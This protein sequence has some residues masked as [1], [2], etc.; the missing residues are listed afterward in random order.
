LTVC[1]NVLIYFDRTTAG[2]TLSGLEGAL[3]PHGMLVIGA[4]D[5]LAGPKPSSTPRRASN[6]ATA[7]PSL[8]RVRAGV[9]RAPTAPAPRSQA[10]RHPGGQRAPVSPGVRPN[11]PEWLRDALRAVHEWN[12]DETVARIGIVLES[13]PLNVDAYFVRGVAQ[14][15]SGDPAGAI[16]SLRRALYLDPGFGLAAFKLARAYE[17]LHDTEGARRA[18]RRALQ[19]LRPDDARD[20]ALLERLDVGNV[21]SACRARL[22]QL[23]GRD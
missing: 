17:D 21:A 13:D 14:L 11:R 19:S 18:Y 8:P 3:H 15:A 22:R 9:Q 4:A 20:A 7:S 5:R 16:A 1:R 10:K 6:A 12:L 2:R 23:D